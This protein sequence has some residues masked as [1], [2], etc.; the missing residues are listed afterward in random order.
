MATITAL[1]KQKR[2]TR[3]NVHLDGAYAFA[4]GIELVVE[5]H[6]AVGRTL[7][8]DEQRELEVEDQRRGAVASALRQLAMQPRSEKDLRDR[9]GRKGYGR[10]AVDAAIVRMR[11]LGYLNDAAYARFYVDARIASTPRS[12]RAIAF[13]LGRKGVERELVSEAVAELSD[14][15]AAYE[16]AR[17]RLRALSALD[18]D[19]FYRRLGSFLASRGFGYG[20]ARSTI[21]RCWREIHE[22][23]DSGE[24]ENEP[25][26]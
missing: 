2:R 5:R 9:L 3:V 22:D 23:D 8:R 14:E 17:R 20:I 21:D 10:V 12:R 13:E 16:A 15:D 7:E 26:D 1:E 11:E 19:K 18:R 24:F 4:L 6:L 25:F